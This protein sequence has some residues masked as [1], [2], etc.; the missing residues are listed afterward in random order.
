MA[1]SYNTLLDSGSARH[2]VRN[3]AFFHDYVEKSISVGTATYGSLVALGRTPENAL[4]SHIR[5]LKIFA[6]FIRTVLAN[7]YPEN[8][9][10]FRF[11]QFLS[12]RP[13][14]HIFFR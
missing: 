13:I 2:V 9:F 6:I 3:R 8:G 14:R 12:G 7:F 11:G 4:R 10:G 1:D 5:N